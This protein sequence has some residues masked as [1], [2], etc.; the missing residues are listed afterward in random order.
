MYPGMR[1]C[2]GRVKMAAL[3]HGGTSG[4]RRLREV[5]GCSGDQYNHNVAVQATPFYCC[6]YCAWE[7]MH[8]LLLREVYALDCFIS[9]LALIGSELSGPNLTLLNDG[10][11]QQLN[12]LSQSAGD[13][14]ARLRR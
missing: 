12:E 3:K 13:Q 5:I 2:L 11:D 9:V 4:W 6:C 14:L 8:V 7:H 1:S 10:Q